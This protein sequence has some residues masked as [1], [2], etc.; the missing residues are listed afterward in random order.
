MAKHFP[1]AMILPLM[2]LAAV[3]TAVAG[4]T[5]FYFQQSGALATAQSPQTSS[6][7]LKK[8]AKKGNLDVK[9]RVALNPNTPDD[10]LQR[11]SRE[12][13]LR[14]YLVFES[15]APSQIIRA[16]AI[17]ERSTIP[18]LVAAGGHKNATIDVLDALSGHSEAAVRRAVAGNPRVQQEIL[19]RLANDET[20]QVARTAREMLDSRQPRSSP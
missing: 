18:M 4:W 2:L 17:D 12:P 8:L 19:N 20:S 13:T 5:Y 6:A 16:V 11:L 3:P 15:E 10:S 9:L 7:D 1:P 14:Y